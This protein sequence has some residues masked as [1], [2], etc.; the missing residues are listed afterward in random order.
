MLSEICFQRIRGN[1]WYGS[2][3]E[4]Q[5][6]INRESGYINASKLCKDG[7]KNFKNWKQNSQSQELIAT[8]SLEVCEAGIPASQNDWLIKNVVTQQHAEEDKVIS[9]S[10]VHADL[11]P[12]IASWVSPQF[13]RMVSR[14]VNAHIV[15]VYK[16]K[17]EAEKVILQKAL[18]AEHQKVEYVDK[19]LSQWVSTHAITMMRLNESG[20]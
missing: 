4:F 12:H 15:Q 14:I 9:G 1:F 19:D 16:E 18:V 20:L 17:S 5:V 7:G 13:A 2:Y 8:F 6:V 3:G 10:Y 11:I